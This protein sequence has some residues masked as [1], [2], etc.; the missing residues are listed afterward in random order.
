MIKATK[1]HS[2]QYKPYGDAYDVWEIKS[3]KTASRKDVM[4]WCRENLIGGKTV[5]EQNEFIR[6]YREDSTFTSCDYFDGFVKLI[7]TDDNSWEFTKVSPY[8]D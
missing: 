8:T 4:A 6:R 7:R 5:P 1:I 3:D 2:G